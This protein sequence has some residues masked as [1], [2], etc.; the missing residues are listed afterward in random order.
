MGMALFWYYISSVVTGLH[1][2]SIC[3]MIPALVCGILAVIDANVNDSDNRKSIRNCIIAF[4]VSASILVFIPRYTFFYALAGYEASKYISTTE[5]GTKVQDLIIKNWRNP[6]MAK[7]NICSTYRSGED[8]PDYSNPKTRVI[9]E[10]SELE[11]KLNSLKTFLDN[12]KAKDFV[13]D[14]MYELL[15]KQ[16][17]AMAAYVDIL[18]ERLNI[19]DL[20]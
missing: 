6:Q 1:V 17:F 14:K 5:I 4:I 7:S 20:Q 15:V 9:E 11:R 16:S 3:V 18:K 2:L 19:W 13:S 12:P 8:C 10:L